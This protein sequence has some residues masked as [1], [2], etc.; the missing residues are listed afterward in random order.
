MATR[1][2][3]TTT[4]RA[5]KPFTSL[6]R[7]LTHSAQKKS[8]TTLPIRRSSYS[9][10]H[11]GSPEET[12]IS[13]L[14]NGLRVTTESTPGHFIGA[15]VYV[16]AGSRYESAYLR[17]STH[18]TDRM[19]F[20]STQNRTTEEISLE[21]EQLG[22]SFFASSGRD[23]VLYQATS[24]PDSL[25]SVLSVLSDTALN[26]L[27][28]DSELAAE[29]EAAEWEVNEINKKP[30]YMIPEILHET[31]FPNNTLGLPLI[32]PK[33]RIHSIT[34]EV[35]WSYRSMFFKPERIVVAGVGVDHDYFLS[36]VE[37]YFG[38]FKSV[39]P[40]V[41]LNTNFGPAISSATANAATVIGSSFTNPSAGSKSL[42]SKAFATTTN[43]SPVDLT[44]GQSLQSFE[45]LISAKPVYRGGEVRIPGKT[46]SNLAHIYI[47]FEA[48]SVHD[49]DLYAIA[50]T[51]IMLGGG[52]SFSAGGPG[53]GMY[54]RLYTNVLNPH[55]E[56]DFCQAFHHTYADAGLF[57]IAM[58]VAPEFA[59]HVPQIIASQLDLIS[60]DQSRGGITEAQ[61]RRAKNQLRSTMMYGLESRLLQVED[62]GRQVQTA[63]RKKPWAD[64]WERIESL[65]I[66]DIHRAITKIIRPGSSRQSSSDGKMFSGE[67]TIVATGMIDRLGDIKELFSRYGIGPA[68]PRSNRFW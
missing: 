64:V 11:H 56:V 6:N 15:G 20:K 45:E 57:G 2:W 3:T 21:I 55:P 25:P 51:H 40:T 4:S 30:E 5:F 27:L 67:P 41:P 18:L 13:T 50:C 17:G 14:S 23:T 48:P 12:R 54:S 19:A 37:Q 61:L 60:R 29:Q 63:G 24:Y 35:L 26:P 59:S 38:N 52:S 33:D 10:T 42:L 8:T 32:C 34:P 43:V 68:L 44:T 22:G 1:R 49:D 28:K 16:D 66:K 31:A 58:A 65:T 53:K 39:K 9:T 62:L 36:H 7:T 46:E 47:G